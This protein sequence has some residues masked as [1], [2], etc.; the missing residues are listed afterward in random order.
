MNGHAACT[1]DEVQQWHWC[2]TDVQQGN[3][4]EV[5]LAAP[6]STS[7]RVEFGCSV[8]KVF[9]SDDQVSETDVTM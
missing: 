3:A 1:A 8:S 4:H 6:T 5:M 2:V 9:D 7:P